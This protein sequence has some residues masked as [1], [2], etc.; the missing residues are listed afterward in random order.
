MLEIIVTRDTPNPWYYVACYFL[1]EGESDLVYTKR[2][3]S[4]E[5]VGYAVD[6][7]RFTP[8]NG[9]HEEPHEGEP[10]YVLKDREEGKVVWS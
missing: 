1:A 3:V 7:H 6:R 2:P 10:W 5:G 8:A 4:R 9:W